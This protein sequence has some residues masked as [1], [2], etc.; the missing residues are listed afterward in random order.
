M[1]KKK[2]TKK[3]TKKVETPAQVEQVTDN[4]P[5]PGDTVRVKIDNK[6]VEAEFIELKPKGRALV[7]YNNAQYEA[8]LTEDDLTPDESE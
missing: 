8:N 6:V 2:A 1:T 4:G 3:T 5:Q 7:I